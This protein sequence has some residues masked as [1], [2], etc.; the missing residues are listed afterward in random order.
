MSTLF[1]LVPDGASPDRRARHHRVLRPVRST[2]RAARNRR[3]AALDRPGDRQGRLRRPIRVRRDVLPLRRRAD[4]AVAA[5]AAGRR[6]GALSGRLRRST[7]RDRPVD[8]DSATRRARPARSLKSLDRCAMFGLTRSSTDGLGVRR[9]LAP[10]PRRLL[11]KLPPHL[12]AAHAEWTPVRQ[13]PDELA[14]ARATSIARVRAQRRRRARGSPSTHLLAIGVSPRLAAAARL[15]RCD[16]FPGRDPTRPTG[17]CLQAGE[18]CSQLDQG[19]G[20]EGGGALGEPPVVGVGVH[21]AGDVEVDPR[22]VADELLQEQR[23]GDRPAVGA[24]DVLEVGDVALEQLAVVVVQRQPPQ[25]LVGRRG[26]RPGP[27]R[28]TARRCETRPAMR[29]PSATTQAPVSVARSTMASG[30]SSTASASASARIEPALGVGVQHLDGLAVA[31]RQH[32]AE[33][34]RAARGHVVRARQLAG[35]LRAALQRL[36][37]GHRPEHRARRR[38]CPASSARACRRSA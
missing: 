25:R 23:R 8:W 18:V 21:R 5:A 4:V 13:Q 14:L 2:A 6:P 27:R 33:L 35:H 36:Q 28:R 26:R 9:K 10:L 37:R 20:A 32:V 3:R 24:A 12:Q 31:D 34:H 22:R 1:A 38:S 19:A 30:C 15:G 17:N 29:L 11:D 7:W 16:P